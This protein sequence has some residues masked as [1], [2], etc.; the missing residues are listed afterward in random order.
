MIYFLYGHMVKKIFK[1]LW[2]T[3]TIL[4]SILSL[5]RNVIEIL[6]TSLTSMWSLTTSVY[7]KPTDCHQYLHYR[8]SHPGHIKGSIVYS[9]TLWASNLCSFKEDFVDYSEEIKTWFSKRG[10]PDKIENEMKKVNLGESR[11]KTKSATGV[12]FVV[13]YHQRLKVLGKIIHENLNLLYMKDEVEDS[14]IPRP[15][16]SFRTSPKRNSYLVRA[17][18]YPLER[19]IGSTKCSKKRCEVCE[20]VQN[21]DRFWS[22]VTSEMFKFNHR[23]TCDE[24]CL[25]YLFTCK[26]GSKYTGKTTDQFRLRW[27]NGKSNDRNLRENL[28]CK[29]IC[30]N[31]L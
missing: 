23:L 4:N 12:P 22:S 13:T 29:N 11:S 19:T 8:S 6:L 30:M 27:N 18:I 17:K 9:Q 1:T 15:M 7:I 10:Y 2:M 20:N 16:V 28:V 26:T 24:K 31:I 5:L 14:F 21:S 3:L 25:V